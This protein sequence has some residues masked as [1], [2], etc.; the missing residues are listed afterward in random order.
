MNRN[1][2]II[3][4]NPKESLSDMYHSL[5]NRLESWKHHNPIYDQLAIEQYQ[6]R[7]PDRK[8]YNP[9]WAM[10][11]HAYLRQTEADTRYKP[12]KQRAFERSM[13]SIDQDGQPVKAAKASEQAGE[14]TDG[15]RTGW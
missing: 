11:F 7:V 15:K 12:A 2:E 3:E 9:S 1:N 6:A 13:R 10:E 14:R 4:N 5:N 8:P